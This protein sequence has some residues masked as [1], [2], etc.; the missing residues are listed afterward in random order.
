MKTSLAFIVV[1]LIGQPNPLSA[2]DTS[3]LIVQGYNSTRGQFPYQVLILIQN[4]DYESF[5]GGT[6]LSDRWIL[7]AAHCIVKALSFKVFF[8]VLQL[9]DKNKAIFRNVNIANSFAHADYIDSILLNDI[10]LLY[11]D[12]PIKFSD[13]IKPVHLP[14]RNKL[15]H[16]I[17]ANASGFGMINTNPQHY[18]SIMQWLPLITIDNFD[19]ASRMGPAV[20]PYVLRNSI[21]CAVGLEHGSVCFG[22][23]GG[24][25]IA[26]KNI[27]I[28]LTS[29]VRDVQCPLSYPSAF[30]RVGHYLDWIHEV[31][32][33]D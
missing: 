14:E 21:I 29:F 26:E 27:L 17:S 25:L 9:S 33:I 12:D 31:T 20:A 23:S 6:L 10:G 3:P 8:G 5:C 4:H 16:H 18:P 24:P 32:K 7:T 19:C 30:T 13:T 1:A 2:L 11:L 15:Y 28:G 22:D